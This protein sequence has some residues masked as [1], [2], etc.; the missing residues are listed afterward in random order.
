VEQDPSFQHR[1]QL[2][3]YDSHYSSIQGYHLDNWRISYQKRIFADLALEGAPEGYRFLDVGVGGMGATTIEAARLGAEAWGVDLSPVAVEKS[4]AVAAQTLDGASLARCHFDQGAAEQLPYPDA[5]FD[6][7]SCIALLEH[8]VDDRR[9]M[10]EILR[11]LKPGGRAF[12]AVPHEYAK[13]PWALAVLYRYS[14]WLESHLRHYSR[15]DLLEAMR[16]L[17]AEDL[18]TIYHVHMPKF[19]Q[20]WHNRLDRRLS[21]PGNATWWAYENQDWALEADDR[22]AMLSMVFQKPAPGAKGR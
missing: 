17:G 21:A 15:A 18:K 8:V 9:A 10:A 19:W 22:S 14:D 13:T 2:R 5:S 4:R 1:R 6:G 7:V 16:S 20:F 11:V 12:L 3:R